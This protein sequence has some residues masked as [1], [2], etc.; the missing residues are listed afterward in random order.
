MESPS[1][2]MSL[3]NSNPPPA[4]YNLLKIFYS[5]KQNI[6]KKEWG[7]LVGL[8]YGDGY[9]NYH[10]KSRHYTIEFFLNSKNFKIICYKI[11]KLKIKL[12]NH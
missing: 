5:M 1:P 3:P 6:S 12:Q 4:I 2:K 7:Y 9:I 8:Y 10:K 11:K